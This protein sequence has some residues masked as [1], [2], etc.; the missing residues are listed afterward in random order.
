MLAIL[1]LFKHQEG[2]WKGNKANLPKKP[3]EPLRT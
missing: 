2:I 1:E 3:A